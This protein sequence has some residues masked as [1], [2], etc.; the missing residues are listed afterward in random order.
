MFTP[1]ENGQIVSNKDLFG[2]QQ[3]QSQPINI[4]FYATGSIDKDFE[5]FIINNQDLIYSSVSAAKSENGEM[6]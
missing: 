3:Q 4:S 1:S 2:Q 6:F 5:S